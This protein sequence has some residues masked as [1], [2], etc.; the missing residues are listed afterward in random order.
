MC[1]VLRTVPDAKRMVTKYLFL[2][3][4]HYAGRFHLRTSKNKKKTEL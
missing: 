4:F 1:K 3:L 2:L